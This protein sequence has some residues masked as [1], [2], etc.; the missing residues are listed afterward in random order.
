MSKRIFFLLFIGLLVG[1]HSKAHFDFNQNCL[2]AYK[3]ILCLRLLEAQDCI[4]QEKKQN[5]NNGIIL[6]LENYYDT[7]SLLTKESKDGLDAFERAKDIRLTLLEKQDKK[8]PYYLY[9]KAEINFQYALLASK[10]KEYLSAMLAFKNA[11]RLLV[12]NKELYPS[13]L[14]NQ[15]SLGVLTA[16]FGALPDNFKWSL[17]IIGIEGDVGKGITMLESL[18]TQ[19][20]KSNYDYLL[21]ETVYYYCTIRIDIVGGKFYPK[22]S[23]YLQRTDSKSLFGT[24]LK[25]YAAIKS[26][27]SAKVIGLLKNRES[28]NVYA[29]FPFLDYLLGEAY[30]YQMNFDE[31]REYFHKYLQSYKG[32]CYQKDV[33]LR[34]SWIALLSG[35]TNKY[36]EYT[37]L[38]STRGYTYHYR[39]EHALHE[40]KHGIPNITLLKARLFFDGGYYP[41]AL[42]L[43]KGRKSETFTTQAERLELFYRL[44]RVCQELNRIPTAIQF[45]L[46]TVQS[47]KNETFYY[48]ANAALKLG[49][50]YEEARDFDKA[51]QYYKMVISMRNNEYKSSLDTKARAGLKRMGY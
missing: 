28:D 13:F 22:V 36:K 41:Q 35:N 29:I 31:A 43:L 48:A 34:L 27:Q 15:K 2:K 5:P 50:I 19:L 45:Y 18:I 12:E 4:S 33:Y 11:Y 42:E 16:L 44:A 30:L 40:I 7:Y 32:V 51:Q 8:S 39:D 6:L 1:H 47:G 10:F 20:P 3:S 21:D 25:A 17:R 38:V 37:H 49:E 24:Y 14:P 26:G 46:I 9:S 23:E